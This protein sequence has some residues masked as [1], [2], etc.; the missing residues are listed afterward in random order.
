MKRI[1]R[2]AR[3]WSATL[4]FIAYLPLL[5]LLLIPLSRLRKAVIRRPSVIWGPTPVFNAYYSAL[6]ARKYGYYCDLL[7]YCPDRISRDNELEIFRYNF[8]RRLPPAFAFFLGP[9][10][11]LPLV[12]LKYDILHFW[13]HGNYLSHLPLIRWLEYPLWKL[14]GKKLIFLPFG[15]DVRTE[16]ETRELGKYNVYRDI[17]HDEV[18]EAYGSD[19][20]IK[21]RV[22]WAIKWADKALTF[23][24]QIHYT[25][26]AEIFH[27]FA[28][29]TDNIKPV[30]ETGNQKTLIVHAPNHRHLKGTK[31]LI[32][33]MEKIKKEGL[34]AEL[35]LVENKTRREAIEIY[36]RADIIVNELICGWHGFFTVEA[37]AL[38]KPVISYIKEEYLPPHD[39]CPIV[40]ANLD[41]IYEQ[42]VRLIKDKPLRLK[43]GKESRRYV[44]EIYSLEK[45]GQR[46]DNL[47]KSLY[48]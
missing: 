8:S 16:R 21:K 29:D 28:V 27:Y 12:L 24:D 3:D 17:S 25:P 23:G 35:L 5:L 42:L 6:S 11:A 39:F 41:N 30:Y 48:L 26:A 36:K 13:Y 46:L 19:A 1:F 10:L 7:T 47:Y 31:Y 9:F 2:K 4:L 34:P 40:N 33:A 37:L 45:T 38:G 32:A 14:A 18:V 43:I 22:A 44:E 20:A 15:S